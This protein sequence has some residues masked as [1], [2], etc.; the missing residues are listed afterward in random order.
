MLFEEFDQILAGNAAVLRTGDAV[1]FESAGVEPFADGPRGHLA[2]LRDLACGEHLHIFGLRYLPIVSESGLDTMRTQSMTVFALVEPFIDK[3]TVYH[4]RI[5][6]LTGT[7][8]V[9]ALTSFEQ[10][11]LFA[12][13]KAPSLRSSQRTLSAFEPTQTLSLSI[14]EQPHPYDGTH[15]LTPSIRIR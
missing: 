14:G 11:I 1:P 9:W 4:D 7:N 3:P 15:L 12:Q 2:D 6:T 5:H 13:R 10:P 8:W